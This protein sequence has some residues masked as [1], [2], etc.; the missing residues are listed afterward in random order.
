MIVELGELISK[1]ERELSDKKEMVIH[2]YEKIQDLECQGEELRSDI[3]KLKAALTVIEK[4]TD[5]SEEFT[6]TQE[7]ERPKL[8]VVERKGKTSPLSCKKPQFKEQNYTEI[9]IN[10]L[11]GGDELSKK[12]LVDKIFDISPGQ[13]KAIEDTLNSALYRLCLNN[14]LKSR[15]Y[16]GVKLYS[17]V[18][19]LPVNVG[20]AQ[21][22]R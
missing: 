16:K 21:A 17:L 19:P 6:P 5:N 14:R 12:T 10:L 13:E 1:K 18:G 7:G 15:N 8:S 9:I 3:E 20:Q 11:E 22:S 4:G 2:L